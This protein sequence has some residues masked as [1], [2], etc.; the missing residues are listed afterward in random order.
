MI[1]EPSKT[2]EEIDRRLCAI[3]DP[4]LAALLRSLNRGPDDPEDYTSTSAP[5]WKRRIGFLALAGLLAMSVSFGYTNAVSRSHATTR[6]K[7]RTV[8]AVAVRRHH[9]AAIHRIAVKHRAPVA[10]HVAAGMPVPA[11]AP[12]PN[13]ALIRHARAQLL[14]ERAMAAQAQAD[15][16]RARYEAKLAMQARAQAQ[17]QALREALAQARAEALAVARAQ[18]LQREQAEA[19]EQR[20]QEQLQQ[21]QRDPQIKPGDTPPADSGRIST[22]PRPGAPVPMPGPIDPNCTPHRGSLFGAVI[23]SAVLSHVRVG[24][25]N[26]GA[27]LQFVHP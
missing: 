9:K 19:L 25:T 26:A 17:E 24:G 13:E 6:A 22:Y 1:L 20:Q 5:Y 2:A 23:T 12:A 18:A 21:A 10:H 7:A 3:N 8:P 15:A 4:E 11:I 27:L 14:H 16:A